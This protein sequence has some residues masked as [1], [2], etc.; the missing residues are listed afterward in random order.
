MYSPLIQNSS[1]LPPQWF[2]T[3]D[4]FGPGGPRATQWGQLPNY[5]G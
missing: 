4:Q 2:R 1:V 5:P 3:V